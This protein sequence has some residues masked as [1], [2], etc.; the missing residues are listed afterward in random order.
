[1]RTRLATALLVAAL[2]G[3]PAA[4]Q[5]LPSPAR[6][7]PFPARD[8][9]L[10]AQPLLTLPAT[11]PDPLPRG[12]TEVRVDGEWGSDFAFVG[13]VRG[14]VVDTRYMVDG[15]HR[16]GALTLR[17]GL[18]RGLT[19]GLRAEVLWRGRGIMDGIIDTW[20]DLLGLPDGGRS[21]FP[22]DRLRIEGRD[23]ERRPIRWQGRGGTGLGN[24]ELEAHQA[25]WGRDGAPAWQGAVVARLSVPTA[26]GVF[27]EAGGGG[28]LQLV[29]ARPLGSRADLYA[30]LGATLLGPPRLE[31]IEY[32]RTRPQGFLALEG[33]I[34]RGWSV[35]VQLDAAGRLVTNVDSYPGSAVY[36]RVGSKF[37]L[38]RWTVEGGV[39][40]GVKNQVAATD[41]GL[42]AALSRRF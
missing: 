32:R 42:V 14:A 41:F 39:T 21:L 16:S 26:T 19:V 28:G 9:W 8:P 10:L 40:E 31:G 24:L 30:G 5:S 25:L 13:T 11:A 33:R 29:V 27:A 3:P 34:T 17:R 18:G 37:G 22:D 36:L 23:L 4:A 1:M 15:E 6:R 7:G 12:R 38:G 2:A 35:I 20:H